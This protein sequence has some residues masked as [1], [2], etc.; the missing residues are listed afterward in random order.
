MKPTTKRPLIGIALDQ[1]VS[2]I[3]SA[4]P[5]Y[6]LREGYS[7]AVE[8]QGGV[9]ILLPP[10][11]DHISR[12]LDLLDG[13]LV[14]GNAADIPP[15]LYGCDQTH[16]SVKTKDQRTEFEVVLIGEARSRNLPFLGICNGLQVLNVICGGTLIQHIPDYN[17]RGLTHDQ[18]QPSHETSHTVILK[19]KTLLHRIMNAHRIEVNSTHH[20]AIDRVGSNL[21]IN[22]WAE[23]GIIEGVEALDQK[24]CLAVQWHPEYLTTP[25][26]HLLF[27]AFIKACQS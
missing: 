15:Q 23:D 4:Y 1:E 25:H 11:K 24:F 14:P 5:W 27:D 10:L 9:P 8:K 17:A 26:D 19:E 20:Q 6:A 13:L 16:P 2:N 22:A 3:Y 18:T 12:Y 7:L 21:V